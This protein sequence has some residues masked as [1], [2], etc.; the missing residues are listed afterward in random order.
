[1]QIG[2]DRWADIEAHDFALSA[3][4]RPGTCSQLYVRA[5]G[6]GFERVQLG[7]GKTPPDLPVNMPACP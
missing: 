6:D 3:N 4:P 7:I 1:M 5:T 2:A